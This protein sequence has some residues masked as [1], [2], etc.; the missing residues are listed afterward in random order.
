[1][2]LVT[3][4]AG[5]IT[6]QC[7]TPANWLRDACPSRTIFV[8][9]YHSSTARCSVEQL[10]PHPLPVSFAQGRGDH[11]DCNRGVSLESEQVIPVVEICPA[12]VRDSGCRIKSQDL[13]LKRSCPS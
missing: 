11:S 7:C 1:M 5:A 4:L 10:D 12:L 9:P 13:Q 8:R 6:A 3:P 2:K